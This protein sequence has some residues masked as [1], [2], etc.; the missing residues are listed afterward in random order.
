MN[1]QC[2]CNNLPS[3]VKCHHGASHFIFTC[4][5]FTVTFLLRRVIGLSLLNAHRI[6]YY[7]LAFRHITESQKKPLQK[8][9]ESLSVKDVV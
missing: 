8:T 6:T 1:Y 7:T 9:S 4:R 2:A 5:S 3:S